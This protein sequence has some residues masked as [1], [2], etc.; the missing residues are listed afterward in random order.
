MNLP[1]FDA[2]SPEVIGRLAAVLLHSLWQASLLAGAHWLTLRCLGGARQEARYRLAVATLAAVVALA[3]FTWAFLDRTSAKRDTAADGLPRGAAQA[4]LTANLLS[5]PLQADA[6]STSPRDSA[7]IV[8]S[9]STRPKTTANAAE[10][11][12]GSPA[13]C[14]CYCVW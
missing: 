4:D 2:I 8:G 1:L 3:V 12:S 6:L 13:W 11:H 5:L 9:P 7:P 14:S 10:S